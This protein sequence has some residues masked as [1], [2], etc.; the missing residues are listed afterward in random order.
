MIDSESWAKWLE[1]YG[2]DCFYD[3]FMRIAQD[4]ESECRHCHKPIYLDIREGEGI[5]DW[6]TEDGDY[7]C[8]DSPDTNAEDGTG[9]HEP[10]KMG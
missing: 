7:G 1:S 3:A 6:R 10:I 8:S 9:S 4:A 5:P 2:A